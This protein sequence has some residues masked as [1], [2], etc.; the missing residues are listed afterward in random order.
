MCHIQCS[1][2]ISLGWRR[3]KMKKEE[4][5]MQGAVVSGAL[6]PMWTRD[7]PTTAVHLFIHSGDWFQRKPP[8]CL[9]RLRVFT[10]SELEQIVHVA[11][12][13]SLCPQ[14]YPCLNPTSVINLQLQ[15]PLLMEYLIS[16]EQ[17]EKGIMMADATQLTDRNWNHYKVMLISC[18][19][20]WWNLKRTLQKCIAMIRYGKC[21]TK[22]IWV[23]LQ[24]A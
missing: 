19:Q 20:I 23:I 13:R 9:A 22:I 1:S 8:V 18:L 15:A 17:S 4:D 5:R 3:S 16:K 6:S 10:F 11:H 2:W 7:H 14:D 12:F 24:S 21:S